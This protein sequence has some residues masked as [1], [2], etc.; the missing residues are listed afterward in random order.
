MLTLFPDR[1]GL[2]PC[3]TGEWLGAKH[4]TML[5]IQAEPVGGGGGNR[6]RQAFRGRYRDYA[7]VALSAA[8]S[9]SRLPSGSRK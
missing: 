5:T 8:M 3:G 6:K 4:S 7:S 1:T 9:S 2:K